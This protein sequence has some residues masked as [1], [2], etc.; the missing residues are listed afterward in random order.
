MA[1]HSPGVTCPP[2]FKSVGQA[3]R[4]TN[5]PVTSAV[6]FQGY[7]GRWDYQGNSSWINDD[8]YA[9]VV[10]NLN[11]LFGPRD[12]IGALLDAGETA[13]ACCPSIVPDTHNDRSHNSS[14]TIPE[15]I[16]V[17][18]ELL[19]SLSISTAC[20]GEWTMVASTTVVSTS[21]MLNGTTR[22]G[23]LQIPATDS[24]YPLAV[25][26]TATTFRCGPDRRPCCCSLWNATFLVHRESDDLPAE[27]NAGGNSNG[28]AG[29]EE[30]ENTGAETN[31]AMAGMYIV[32]SGWGQIRGMLGVIAA[33]GLLGVLLILH[34]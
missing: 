1:Y 12:A 29:T 18:Y 22:T 28:S 7:P 6:I 14:M 33:S 34:V 2:G 27:D 8:E 32:D 15:D 25:T 11:V 9:S 31:G 16:G 24:V 5:G 20:D 3:A 17:C 4:P 19:P 21:Y 23:N 30:D 10:S 13:I 26:S